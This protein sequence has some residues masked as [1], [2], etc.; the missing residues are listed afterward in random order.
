M[1]KA[2]DKQSPTDQD[3]ET[4]MGIFGA[5]YIISCVA[6]LLWGITLSPTRSDLAI[7]LPFLMIA[8]GQM[9]GAPLFGALLEVTG[10]TAAFAGAAFVMACATI[11]APRS[12]RRDAGSHAEPASVM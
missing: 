4:L 1:R 7:G 3:G 5:G 11:P 12:A 2:R 9:M 10:T 8:F 6:L